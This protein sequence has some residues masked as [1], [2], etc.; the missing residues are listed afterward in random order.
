[1]QVN[2][3]ESLRGPVKGGGGWNSKE[4]RRVVVDII[5]MVVAVGIVIMMILRMVT[6]HM[7]R[8]GGPIGVGA[9][10]VGVEADTIVM[11]VTM[12]GDLMVVGI[13]I[14]EVVAR[15]ATVVNVA[16]MIM[17]MKEVGGGGTMTTSMLETA[18]I[19]EDIELSRS[20]LCHS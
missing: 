7:R 8:L 11:E 6:I 10:V 3:S 15:T 20:T 12:T 14:G 2:L 18:T 17:I 5:I 19:I 1:M 13:M 16:A 9:A 4:G